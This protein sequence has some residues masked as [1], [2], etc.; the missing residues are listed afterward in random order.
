MGIDSYEEFL[1]KILILANISI[2]YFQCK[3]SKS[4]LYIL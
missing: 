3:P 4:G 1:Y 2:N